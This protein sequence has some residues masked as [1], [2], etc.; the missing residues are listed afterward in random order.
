MLYGNLTDAARRVFKN[1][2]REA[3][4]MGHQC[5]GEGHLLLGLMQ[6]TTS[7]GAMT[8]SELGVELKDAAGV[9]EKAIEAASDLVMGDSTF[10]LTPHARNA[11]EH[12][13]EAARRM[14]SDAVGTEH[15]LLGLASEK[16][17][18]AAQVLLVLGVEL[19]EVRKTVTRLAGEGKKASVFVP[20]NDEPP[21]AVIE[22]SAPPPPPSAP[23]GNFE[24]TVSGSFSAA[25]NLR[26]YKGNC[27]RLHGHN[28]QVEVCLASN[29]LDKLGMVMDFREFREALAVVLADM[30]HKYLN[31]IK[32]FDAINPTTENVCWQIAL[33]LRDKLPEHVTIRRVTCWES[34]KCSASY[35]P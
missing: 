11:F 10:P 19:S 9:V 4:R 34:E 6:E 15:L 5:I 8:L 33:L 26:E 22:T 13:V 18:F 2:K 35:I 1:A 24:L 12:A 7:L 23:T 3:K 31:E 17:G 28:W 29:M 20:G 27:E 32:P 30:D 14:G 25:H 16:E 21:T